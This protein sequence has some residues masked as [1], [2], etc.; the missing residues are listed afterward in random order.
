MLVWLLA[1]M[2]V[3]LMN[4]Y[5]AG[6][7]LLSKAGFKVYMGARDTLPEPSVLR[8]RA[9]KAATNYSENLPIFLGL[10]ILS[11]VVPDANQT[12]ALLGAQIF[13]LTRVLYIGL[14][15]S[16][17]PYVRSIAFTGGAVGLIMMAVALF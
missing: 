15:L 1:G 14:Y 4:V 17:V 6:W 2:L 16:G 9:L 13:V 11:F 12:L 5:I 10:G 8:G 7:F 3:Y